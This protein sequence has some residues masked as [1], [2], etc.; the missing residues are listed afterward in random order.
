[1]VSTTM[2]LLC[3]WKRCSLVKECSE[4]EVCL[5]IYLLT[6][7]GDDHLQKEEKNHKNITF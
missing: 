7:N 5:F 6:Q 1:M 4:M 2:D 3:P